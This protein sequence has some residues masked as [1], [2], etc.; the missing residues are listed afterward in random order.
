VRREKRGRAQQTSSDPD[1][2]LARLD[3]RRRTH[4]PAYARRGAEHCVEA[5]SAAAHR[6]AAG[7][8]EHLLLADDAPRSRDAQ[9]SDGL[10]RRPPAQHH[11]VERDE[12]PCAPVASFAVNSDGTVRMTLAHLEKRLHDARAR[13]VA[14]REAEV[15][16]GHASICEATRI[17]RAGLVKANDS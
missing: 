3:P 2:E 16:Q 1:P 9:P 17:V 14:V 11:D 4:D 6:G 12:S 10:A 13:R 5:T 15:V 7:F 8:E